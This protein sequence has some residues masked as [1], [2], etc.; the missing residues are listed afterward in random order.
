MFVQ[1]VGEQE[2]DRRPRLIVV[3][4]TLLGQQLE[5]GAEVVTI[6]RS[7]DC[8]ISFQH[9]SVS[10]QHCRIWLED[11]AYWIQDLGSTNKTYVNGHAISKTV[12]R[13][14]DQIGVGNNALKY[15]AGASM[16]AR[17]HQELI[18]LAIYDSLTGFFNRRHF[19]QLM[20]EQLEKHQA[21]ALP[22]CLI[23]VDLDHFKRIND[24]HGHLV[25]DHV[26][27]EVASVLRARA[28]A[29]M[30]IGRLGGEEFAVLL[31]EIDLTQAVG[32]AEQLRADVEAHRFEV[33]GE[34]LPVTISLGVAQFQ[35]SM[36]DSAGLLREADRELY[37]A[38]ESGRN[39][40]YPTL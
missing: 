32:F 22:L 28:Q 21:S 14:G 6:G 30:A 12:L 3:S 17:Y 38:K 39:R 13:D 18:D 19:R 7:S 9:P 8:T 2:Q 15:F 4:G 26:L 40:V 27:G 25:G 1:P 33:R 20:D 34:A 35:E 29:S 36:R 24:E 16:E 23:I 31:P 10:R 11:G 5:L 37:R